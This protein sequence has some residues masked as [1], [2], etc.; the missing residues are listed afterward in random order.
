MANRVFSI[1]IENKGKS[2]FK[3]EIDPSYTYC[4]DFPVPGNQYDSV[5]PNGTRAKLV[6]CAR[7]QGHGCDGRNGAFAMRPVFENDPS[8]KGFQSFQMDND[9]G[10]WLVGLGPDYL[11][12]LSGPDAEG[13]YTWTVDPAP[14]SVSTDYLHQLIRRLGHI[15]AKVGQNSASVTLIERTERLQIAGLIPSH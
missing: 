12:Q 5:P 13:T 10:L 7:R 8:Q 3:I 14:S 11:S 9:G 2:A 6:Q 15:F 4:M 1:N